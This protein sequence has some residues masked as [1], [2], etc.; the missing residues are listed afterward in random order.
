MGERLLSALSALHKQLGGHMETGGKPVDD[1]QIRRRVRTGIEKL[2]GSG[3][4][5]SAQVAER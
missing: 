2:Q 3:L 1:A 5:V 4:L